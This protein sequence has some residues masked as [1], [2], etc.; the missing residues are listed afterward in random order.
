MDIGRHVGIFNPDGFNNYIISIIGLGAIGSGIAEAL[1]R[2]GLNN[3]EFIDPDSVE[4]H[5]V[6]NQ[7][8][9][10]KDIG[11]F[12]VDACAE[13]L[14]LINPKIRIR[15]RKELFSD[16]MGTIVF[17]ATDNMAARKQVFE[18]CKKNPFV[19]LIID[20]RMASLNFTVHTVDM[21][22]KKDILDYTK[23][24]FTDDKMLQIPCTERSIIF[25]VFGVS[26]FL[27]NQLI[28]FLNQE[29]YFNFITFDYKTM[30]FARI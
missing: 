25:N 28:K 14:K 20:G 18:Y 8:Y 3:F 4:E 27:A 9:F 24:L 10:S 6:P 19:K 26:S 22:K 11:K 15:L 23:R 7:L 29:D 2:M 1:T 21:E 30:T 12:K 5:N 16:L 17:L 13:K